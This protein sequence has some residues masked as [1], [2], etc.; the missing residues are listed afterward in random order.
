MFWIWSCVQYTKPF[1]EASQVFG[2]WELKSAPI[3]YIPSMRRKKPWTIPFI[4]VLQGDQLVGCL[5]IEFLRWTNY[6][7]VGCMK[8]WAVLAWFFIKGIHFCGI[9]GGIGLG[10]YLN[11]VFVATTIDSSL[12]WDTS[13]TFI[14][15]SKATESG[16]KPY[17]SARKALSS[18]CLVS[19]VNSQTE[20]AELASL[21]LCGCCSL[22]VCR[23]LLLQ[24]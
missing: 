5:Q 3:P 22:E 13:E 9:P 15:G 17:S 18:W 2:S 4:I 23:G 21:C 16:S 24:H 7:H 8:F 19:K 1:Q 11:A 12:N 20:C 10:P 14:G 6:G